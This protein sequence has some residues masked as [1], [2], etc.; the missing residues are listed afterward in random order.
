MRTIPVPSLVVLLC[1]VAVNSLAAQAE[2]P[3]VLRPIDIGTLQ[4]GASKAPKVG[5]TAMDAKWSAYGPY[6]RRMADTVQI[7]WERLILQLP[8]R[9]AG[10]ST[11]RVKFVMNDQGRISKITGV[12][13]V[14]VP[15]SAKRACVSAITDRAPYGPW[16]DDMKAVLGTQQEMTFTFHFQ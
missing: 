8:D 5:P 9:P 16:T 1:V 14:D 7:Q 15:A 3:S 12:E 6:L 11:V 4:T 2:H 10:G 13:S